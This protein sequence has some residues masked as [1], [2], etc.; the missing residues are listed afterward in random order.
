MTSLRLLAASPLAALSFGAVALWLL[1]F[2]VFALPGQTLGS[3]TDLF[4]FF[5]WINALDHGQAPHRDFH[6]PHG[7]LAHY[8]P[9]WGYRLAGQYGGALEMASVL[10]LGAV[11]PC[12]V[13]ALARG[14]ALPLGL[15][16]LIALAALIV[17][18]WNPGDGALVASQFLFYNRWCWAALGALFLFFLSARNNTSAVVEGLAVAV[19]LLFLFFTKMSYFAVGGVFVAVF[20]IAFRR[21]SRPA[22]IGLVVF[23]GATLAVQVWNDSVD[24]YLGD[25]TDAVKATGFFWTG[26]NSPFLVNVLGSWP[27]YAALAIA[28]GLAASSASLTRVDWTFLLFV[29]AASVAILAQNGAQAC[30]FALVAAFP[31]LIDCCRGVRRALA[32][33]ALLLFLLPP[34]LAQGVAAFAF[35]AKHAHYAPVELPRMQAVLFSRSE[36]DAI[37][38]LRSGLALLERDDLASGGLMAFDFA[39]WFP[40]FL[41]IAPVK[42]RLWCYHVGRSV[43]HETAPP[44][45]ATFANVRHIMVP[46]FAT[47]RLQLLLKSRLFD[48]TSV[49][50]T[51]PRD[52]LLDVYGDFVAR[53]FVL[54]DENE[55]WWL[56]RRVPET[57]PP[58]RGTA[59]LPS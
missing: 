50:E 4:Q 32:T 16:I 41:D 57:A 1:G 17:V 40:V 21:F 37:R 28:C 10:A 33:S 14:V 27:Q 8:F 53:A 13:V 2:C 34:L 11:L 30:V 31:R 43:S 42:G 49:T 52:F 3:H 35:T 39:N 29:V 51:S 56:L 12:A 47:I 26:S 38:H 59:R 25:V 23:V 44:A 22:A 58:P 9:Y 55:H 5:N 46:K 15:L 45:S 54:V 6:T 18:P 19:L 36:H 20:G 48:F 7:A 24:D